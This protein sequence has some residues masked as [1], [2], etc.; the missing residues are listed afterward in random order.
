MEE[1]FFHVHEKLKRSLTRHAVAGGF[2][3]VPTS[4]VWH[5]NVHNP[6]LLHWQDTLGAWTYG[7]TQA[8]M[9]PMLRGLKAA[10]PSHHEYWTGG[11]FLEEQ[12]RSSTC[13]LCQ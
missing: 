2:S 9:L 7:Q 8:S 11:V 5:V 10:L 4:D 3:G 13:L 6:L 12:A 1:E